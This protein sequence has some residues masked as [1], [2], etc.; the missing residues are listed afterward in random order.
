MAE[1]QHH[2]VHEQPIAPACAIPTGPLAML[3]E[4]EPRFLAVA[5]AA[6][7][8][9]EPLSERTRA[10]L[11]LSPTGAAE[12]E[13]VLDSHPAIAWVQLPWAGIDAFRSLIATRPGL[14][15]TSAKGA[16]AQPVAEH[17]LMLTLALLRIIPERLSTR[18]WTEREGGR[19]LFGLTVCVVGA[20]GIARV[21]AELLAPFGVRLRVVRNRAQD[22]PSAEF[23]TTDIHEGVRDAHVVILAAAHTAESERII[24]KRV[25]AEMRDDAILVN[26]ARGALIDTDALVVALQ[27]GRL[28]GAGIDVTD[29]E[30]LPA[31]HPLWTCPNTIVTPH[32][33]DTPTMTEPLLAER[34]RH[35]ISAWLSGGEYI[36]VVS[37]ELGY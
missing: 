15:W 22:F 5:Q 34:L 7:A 20:G 19:S 8:S 23:V 17:A 3:P 2:S 4:T 30:P 33:A 25:L 9:V 6:G 11:W 1:A 24:D 26:V 14:H 28:G 36:G 21:L 27:S 35:N 16:Y 10:L 13:A 37:A 29:P 32:V 12:L 31:G 18:S